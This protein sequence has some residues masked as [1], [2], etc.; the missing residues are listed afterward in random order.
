[1]KKM[2]L[3]S[4]GGILLI[5]AAFFCFSCGETT[6][7]DSCKDK[8]H[9]HVKNGSNEESEG[10]GGCGKNS[11]DKSCSSSPENDSTSLKSLIP[12][13]NL[14]EPQLQKRKE[15]LRKGIFSKVKSVTEIETGYQFTFEEPKEFSNDLL[16]FINFERNCCASFSYALIFDA[17]NS[18]TH[19]QM[20]GSKEIKAELKN[21][22][23]ELGIL[24][25]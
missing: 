5:V 10:C 25:K 2:I 24:K 11:C 20:Y 13:C 18:A 15:E 22:F 19:L 23:L 1:M 21:G 16:E 4:V 17:D 14:S 7:G 12:S 9:K 8:E 6:C 3:L